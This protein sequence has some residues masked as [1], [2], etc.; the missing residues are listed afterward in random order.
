MNT[1]KIGGLLILTLG[2]PLGLIA[3]DRVLQSTAV[4]IG[5]MLVFF[6]KE[7]VEDE[8]V[9]LLKMKAMFTAMSTGIGFTFMAHNWIQRVKSGWR[10]DAYAPIPEMS[11][12][13]FL[14]GI[15]LIALALF[16]FWRWQDG[17]STNRE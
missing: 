7:R 1:Q 16:H 3:S 2:A 15:L 13:E 9:Q 6:A 8:R 10:G 12:W 14:A 5:L 4:C 11:A 17:R